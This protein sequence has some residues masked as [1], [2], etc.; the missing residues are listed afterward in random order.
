MIDGPLARSGDLG[1]EA[2]PA[3]LEGADAVDDEALV[4]VGEEEEA[5]V[6]RGEP[7]VEVGEGGSGGCRA[8]CELEEAKREVVGCAAVRRELGAV[9]A[10]ESKLCDRPLKPRDA[11]GPG[12]VEPEVG[13]HV[14]ERGAEGGGIAKK[15]ACRRGAGSERRWSRKQECGEQQ[16]PHALLRARSRAGRGGTR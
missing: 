16:R 14:R 12:K 15:R 10:R 11:L 2:D 9:C 5:E 3:G 13:C 8:Q 1:L 7:A 4:R 6:G